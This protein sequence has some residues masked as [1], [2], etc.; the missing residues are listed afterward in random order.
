MK[1]LQLENY[2]QAGSPIIWYKSSDYAYATKS[3]VKAAKNTKYSLPGGQTLT[4]TI[5]FWD[6]SVGTYQEGATTKLATAAASPVAPLADLEKQLS[7]SQVPHV[8]ILYD[9]HKFISQPYVWR[10][11]ISL[12]I[13]MA[14]T[15]S[16]I[17]IISSEV[18]VPPEIEN[19]VTVLNYPL[20]NRE[21]LASLA[22]RTFKDNNIS[23]DRLDINEIVDYGLGLSR[24]CFLNSL[25]LL[26]STNMINTQSACQ[27]IQQQKENLIAQTDLL[28]LLKSDTDF[29]SLAGLD[30]MKNF[31]KRMID[32]G[33]G[34][35]ILI[36][37][38]PGAGKTAFCSCLGNEVGRPVLQMD[39]SRLMG[40]IVGETESKT[41]AA[42]EMVDAMQPAIL[43]VDE[44]EKGLAGTSGGSGDSGTSKRQGGQ[45]LKWLSDHD[46]DVYV[47]ATANDLSA[48]PS[49]FLRA[50]RWDTIFF[51]DV[52]DFVQ[53]S[54]IYDIY[55]KAYKLEADSSCPINR[56]EGWT[57][58]EIKSLCRIA[59]GTGISLA[60]ATS[61]VVPMCKVAK[62]K[63]D[64]LR[65]AAG[66]FAISANDVQGSHGTSIHTQFG[67]NRMI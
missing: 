1:M 53:A 52:P 65:N 57:G 58:A 49:E 33:L 24:T 56:L 7:T 61:M 30:V 34:R 66:K 27:L 12:A 6:V 44:I 63:L 67:I 9:Y 50:E 11:L 32:G 26:I 31:T 39:F 41:A 59:K 37:G 4:K 15:N 48:L 38:V 42:L 22:T 62:D 13:K 19:Y 14:R 43:F 8:L 21:E 28:R 10:S 17:V 55:R 40:G 5:S 45:F 3:V 16:N 64:N 23:I 18:L 46:S 47:V 2:L 29:S 20:P 36:L 60:Q 54:A 51:V 25:Y 35:G